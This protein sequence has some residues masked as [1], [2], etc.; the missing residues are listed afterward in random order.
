MPGSARRHNT[1]ALRFI[2]AHGPTPLGE[3]RGRRYPISES[4]GH[5]AA[6]RCL[7]RGWL[8]H[9]MLGR[10]TLTARGRAE[11]KRRNAKEKT[12]G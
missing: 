4:G 7:G 6:C 9:D 2:A 1:A 5:S 3:F 10:L 8:E 11:L 12:D